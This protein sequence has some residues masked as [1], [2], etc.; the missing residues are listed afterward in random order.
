MSALAAIVTGALILAEIA[1]EI[2]RLVTPDESRFSPLARLRGKRAA[3]E[4]AE[5]WCVGL[6]LHDRIDQATYQ[7]RMS[8]LAHGRRRPAATREDARRM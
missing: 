8:T 5:R 3:L 1:Y 4:D 7:Q 6:R 2:A